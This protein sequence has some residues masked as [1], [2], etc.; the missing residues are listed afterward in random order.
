MLA[1]RQV[2]FEGVPVVDPTS[3][4]ANV[5]LDISALVG[6]METQAK[7]VG[8]VIP[9][10][11]HSQVDTLWDGD[12]PPTISNLR[13]ELFGQAPVPLAP[14]GNGYYHVTIG[15][16]DFAGGDGVN[17]LLF[18]VDDAVVGF[19]GVTPSFNVVG[20]TILS[21]DQVH[22]DPTKTSSQRWL[23]LVPDGHSHGQDIEVELTVTDGQS[24]TTVKI[25]VDVQAEADVPDVVASATSGDWDAAIPVD[26]SVVSGDPDGS[27]TQT[28]TVSGIDKGSILSDGVQ[29]F[30]ATTDGASV[31]VSTWN[32]ASLTITPA[33]GFAVSD[34]LTITATSA[35][36]SGGPASAPDTD[37]ADVTINRPTYSVG[38]GGIGDNL[39][40]VTGWRPLDGAGYIPGWG[41]MNMSESRW[42]T[43]V[44]G[45][46]G[47]SALV[48]ETGQQDGGQSGGGVWA[49]NEATIDGTKAYRYEIYV[50]KHDLTKHSLYFGLKTGGYVENATTG[51]VDTNPYF[52]AWH[53]TTQQAELDAS[54]WYKVVGYVLPQGHAPV[55]WGEYGGVYDTTTGHKVASVNTFRWNANKP[56]NLVTA[57]FFNFYDETQLGYTTYWQPPTVQQVDMTI[58]QP[59]IAE[60]VDGAYIAD[61][62]AIDPNGGGAA[63]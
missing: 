54:H 7:P 13:L 1:G 50:R 32:L 11:I 60:A 23:Q 14:D 44:T 22:I 38:F 61:L 3:E 39:V 52:L 34:Q 42:R 51:A 30:E 63:S 6:F 57:R 2:L 26:V 29:S 10:G 46:D 19:A 21:S 41:T 31:D 27:E 35:E 49:T 16:N 45:P 4:N 33:L 58:A 36:I 9:A 59:K 56:D 20:S 5:R 25:F 53:T 48:L 55:G 47:R 8:S 40:D 28:V 37:I 12:Q 43:D 17:R 24:P 15:E 18:D 62:S